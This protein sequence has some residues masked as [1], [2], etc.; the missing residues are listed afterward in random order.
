MGGEGRRISR[1]LSNSPPPVCCPPRDES[2]RSTT[3]VV[4]N[5]HGHIRDKVVRPLV[6][7]V[8]EHR[9]NAPEL[10]ADPGPTVTFFDHKQPP[11]KRKG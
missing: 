9:E 6:P 2:V 1:K 11:G 4:I 5:R 7:R 8:V 10:L 3:D